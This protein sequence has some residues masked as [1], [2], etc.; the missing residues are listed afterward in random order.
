MSTP[1]GNLNDFSYRGVET[2][3]GVSLILAEDTRR[4]GKLLK[5]HKISQP[6]LSYNEHNRD[7]RIPEIIKKLSAGD[8]VALISD[9]GTPSISDPGYKLV[10]ACISERIAVVAVPGAS[11]ILAGLVASGLPTD[12]FVFEGFLPKKKGR[13]SRLKVLRSED[14]TIILFE[15]PERVGRTLMDCLEY[16]GDRPTAVC[17]EMTKLYEEIWRGRLSEGVQYFDGKKVKGEVTILIGK[18]SESVHFFKES[19]SEPR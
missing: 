1:I 15:S 16:F 6:M 13:V 17:R 8:D 18:N 14:R 5:H 2:L 7:R 3:E 4:S 19:G 11:A 10:R 9:A 12:R